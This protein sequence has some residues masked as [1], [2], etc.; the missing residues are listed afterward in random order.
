MNGLL[1][2]DGLTARIGARTLLHALQLQVADAAA[3]TWV[4]PA[5]LPIGVLTAGLGAPFFLAL[6]L[7]R[8]LQGL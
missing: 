3:R 7:R 1:H 5:E 8:R 6:L 4:A 2:A